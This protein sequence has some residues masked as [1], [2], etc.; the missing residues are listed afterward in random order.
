VP[1]IT[2]VVELTDAHVGR[3]VVGTLTPQ[4]VIEAPLLDK[5]VGVTDIET[6]KVPLLPVALA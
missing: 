6:P 5:V 3:G 2:Q 1:E 4:D